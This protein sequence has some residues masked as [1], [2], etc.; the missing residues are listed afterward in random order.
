M[1]DIININKYNC[2]II[3]FTSISDK[4]VKD[5]LILISDY[6]ID[7]DIVG[8]T[9][10]YYHSLVVNILS[11]LKTHKNAGN[12][13]I[14]VDSKYD[15]P[16]IHGYKDVISLFLK[17]F[18][19]R[20]FNYRGPIDDIVVKIN[21]MDEKVVGRMEI[22]LIKNKTPTA[23]LKKFRKFLMSHGLAAVERIIN[24]EKTSVMFLCK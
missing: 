22:A 8:I 5:S 11:L 9:G 17:S 15:D 24:S 18:T 2:S 1:K 13:L 16:R 10:F 19:L 14:Y 20:S 12:I 6:N 7:I 3:N 4:S 23:K 21:N